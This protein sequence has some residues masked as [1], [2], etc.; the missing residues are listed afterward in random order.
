MPGRRPVHG[1]ETA[2]RGISALMWPY[3]PLPPG[4]RRPVVYLQG[5]AGTGKTALLDTLAERI[6][7]KVPHARAGFA[8]RR[9][10]DVPGTLSDLAGQLSRH[11]PR[12][13]RLRFPRL[14]IG[15]LVQ[16]ADL[17]LTRYDFEQARRVVDQL[18]KRR[19]TG[20]RFQRLL[21]QLLGSPPQLSI[22]LGPTV[23]VLRLPLN[24]IAALLGR[25]FP[26][27]SLRWFGHRDREL[28]DRP[29]DT[30]VELSTWAR[31]ARSDPDGAAGREAR[32]RAAGLLCEAFLADLRDAPRRVRRLRT[33]VLLL[34]D[35]DAEPGRAF[36]RTLLAAR[37]PLPP[38]G[39]PE[40]LTVVAAGKRELPEMADAPVREL[41]EFTAGALPSGAPGPSAAAPGSAP[42][43]GPAGVPAGAGTPGA[44]PGGGAPSAEADAEYPLWLRHR[45]SDLTRFDIT[46]ML[47]GRTDERLATVIHDFTAGHPESAALLAEAALRAPDPAAGVG[48]LLPQD[49]PAEPDPAAAAAP[50]GGTVEERLLARLLPVDAAQLPAYARCAAARGEP[51]GLRLLYHSGLVETALR[52][53]V[54]RVAPWERSGD[55][56]ATVLRRLLLRRLGADPEEWAAVHGRLRTYCAER[57][58][59][60]GE[61]YHRLALGELTPVAEELAAL[62]PQLPGERWLRLLREATA[63]PFTLAEQRGGTP[64]E[65][66]TALVAGTPAQDGKGG[67]VAGIVH[68]VAALRIIADPAAGIVRDFLYA[69]TA[70]TLAALAGRSPDGLVVLHRAADDYRERG[71]R[72]S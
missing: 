12:Y 27:R 24:A 44:A 69:Q 35:A 15:L 55:S 45:L 3:L 32:N 16:E 63:A 31:L 22:Q 71:Q 70:S 37:A 68:L 23:A 18:V 1:R 56:G 9:T 67:E 14:I 65:V 62:L 58:D 38:G 13:R 20:N 72:W 8:G 36:L 41:G 4:R 54:R 40:P 2:L 29:V 48:A 61:L 21:K 50:G 64:Y 49:L 46:R 53:E 25:T 6:R 30:L 42:A 57:E 7:Q 59:R 34:D 60:V 28:T 51:D 5:G 10:E 66:F 19:L 43:G 39:R 17:D 11:R 26:S 33:P 47:G 52:E